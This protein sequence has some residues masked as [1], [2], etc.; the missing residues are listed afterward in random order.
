MTDAMKNDTPKTASV[1]QESTPSASSNARPNASKSKSKPKPRRTRNRRRAAASD[2]GSSGDEGGERSDNS[3]S[4]RSDAP[5]SDSENEPEQVTATSA[6]KKSTK[7]P[8]APFFPDVSSITP[9]LWSEKDGE[10]VQPVSFE[11]F[12]AGKLPSATPSARGTGLSI[13]G[14]GKGKLEPVT[15]REYTPEETA[16]YEAQKA[17]RKEKTKAKKAALKEEKVQEVPVPKPVANGGKG[18]DSAQR[19]FHSFLYVPPLARDSDH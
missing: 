15:K 14:R 2:H 1:T 5:G 16:K 3:L 7:P 6:S 10:D 18:A 8:K 11:D 12:N 13:R 4:S 9:A 19:E 17:K